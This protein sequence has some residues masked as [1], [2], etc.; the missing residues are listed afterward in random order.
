MTP[1]D[2]IQALKAQWTNW[3]PQPDET[4]LWWNALQNYTLEDINRAIQRYGDSEK[5]FKSPD[6]HKLLEYLKA[7]C[8]GSVQ[9]EKAFHLEFW[10]CQGNRRRPFYSFGLL[11]PWQYVG[12]LAQKY[13][14][15]AEGIY[16]GQWEIERGLEYVQ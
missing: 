6:R 15:M 16:G 8:T 13:Q 7:V 11:R 5:L 12:M 14:A 2:L 1:P 3:T 10:I 9:G 4:N